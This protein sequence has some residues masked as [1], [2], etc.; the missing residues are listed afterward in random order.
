VDRRPVAEI[1][2]FEF[3]K[4][5]GQNPLLGARVSEIVCA[6]RK[7]GYCRFFSNFVA[8]ATGVSRGRICLT[9]SSPTLDR[10]IKTKIKT[11][12]RTTVVLTILSVWPWPFKITWHIGHVTNQFAICHFLIVSHCGPTYNW[13]SIFNRLRNIYPK[14]SEHTFSV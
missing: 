10:T 2:L 1:W 13:G 7:S 11:I 3:L 8:M 5:G 12:L 14:A 6:H 4:D 9:F